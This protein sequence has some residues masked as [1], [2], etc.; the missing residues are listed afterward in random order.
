MKPLPKNPSAGR[1]PLPFL[2]SGTLIA[3][4]LLASAP[5]SQAVSGTWI[6][7]GSNG[8]WNDTA[9]WQNGVVASDTDATADF[10]SINITADI[11]VTLTAPQTA[12]NLVFGDTT[13]S[14]GWLLAGAAANNLTLA[15][16][17]GSPTITVNPLSGSKTAL[18][19]AVLSGTQ[20]ITKAGTGTLV[21][22]GSNNYSGGTTISAGIL[23]V[24]SNATNGTLGSGDV[25]IGTGANLSFARSGTFTIS[26]NISGAGTLTKTSNG[27]IMILT[28]SATYSGGTSLKFGTLQAGAA[29]VLS[30]NSVLTFGQSGGT[31]ATLDLG[32]GNSSFD[33]TIGGLSSI[34]TAT[35][36]IITNS[37][38]TVG[39]VATLTVNPDGATVPADSTFAGII[40]DGGSSAIALT[41]AGSRTLTLSG[42]STYTG[43]TIVTGGTLALGAAGSIAN[44]S[45]I[46]AGTIAGSTAKF[47]VSAVA[48][49]YHLTSGQTLAGQGFVSGAVTI[50]SGA[51]LSPADSTAA[52]KLTTNS[53]TFADGGAH[54]GIQ[55][56]QTTANDNDQLATDGGAAYAI[57]LNGADLALTLGSNYTQVN[58]QLF[59]IVN[60][61]NTNSTLAGFFAQGASITVSGNTFNIIYG[62]NYNSAG[63]FV[64]MS[65]GND[66][67]LQAVPEP[68]TWAMMLGG[69][70]LLAFGQR[71]R[72]R[73]V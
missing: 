47:N 22:T 63:T 6:T 52:G 30:P 61:A 44:S 21:L 34:S 51:T 35:G 12:G 32:N 69:L 24:G 39:N 59:L 36:Y 70:G 56:G 9:N 72:R 33:Q 60:N 1:T 3:V 10:N 26:N 43:P 62:A 25:T 16:T 71:M 57:T 41:K 50:D 40:K 31:A 45:K 58:D 55:L 54:L 19:S 28:G 48:G 8:S 67:A 37:D 5:L 11:T 38:A 64:G 4:A 13:S 46:I 49:G 27:G 7:T 68:A 53:V 20:G 2:R 42:S 18:I 65:G 29:N 23:Q 17:S 73:H 66:I 15:T 14:N